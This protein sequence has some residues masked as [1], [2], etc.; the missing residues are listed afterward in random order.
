MSEQKIEN[1]IT[2]VLTGDAQKN[3][4]ELA[5]YLRANGMT[6]E[7]GG[8][9]WEDKLY[10]CVNYKDKS[11]CYILIEEDSW[12]IWSDD[13]GVNSFVN[14]IPEKQMK[15]IAWKH[16]VICENTIRCFDGCGRKSKTIF[17]KEF[18]NVCVTT[19]KFENPDAETIECMKKLMEIRKNDIL[20]NI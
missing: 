13:S 6:F 12:E 17:G 2:E 9:Y 19:M 16:L 20:R 14:F 5:A 3:A 8:G 1:Y 15:E 4:L 11:V 10:W 18:D 7:R